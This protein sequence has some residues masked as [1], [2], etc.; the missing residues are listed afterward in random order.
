MNR[1]SQQWVDV[2]FLDQSHFVINLGD[3][4]NRW[5]NDRWVSTLHRV[6]FLPPHFKPSKL[7]I[8]NDLSTKNW[9]DHLR[10]KA[11]ASRI[12]KLYTTLKPR[13]KPN[14]R[15]QSLAFFHNLNHDANVSAIETCLEPG[16]SPK[17]PPI[18]AYDHLMQKHFASTSGMATP[19]PSPSF[20][21]PTLINE[22]AT[23]LE[24][25]KKLEKSEF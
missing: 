21:P 8:E 16:V 14:S 6:I 24:T 1:S 13:P 7:A 18:L 23:L 15:R 5:T 25:A 11:I 22:E 3:L 17:W 9:F 2:P 10:P 20:Q 4:M 12:Q 19:T